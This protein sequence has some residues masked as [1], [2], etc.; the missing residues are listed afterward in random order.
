M[1][2]SALTATVHD[3]RPLQQADLRPPLPEDSVIAGLVAA[4]IPDGATLQ[5]GVGGTPDA[6]LAGLGEKNDLGVHSGMISDAVVD[7]I[8]A[9]VVTNRAKGID[10]GVTVTGALFGSDRLYS[11][12]DRNPMFAMRPVT[13]THDAAVLASV[14]SLY[15]INSAIEV[16]LTGQVNGEVAAGQYVGTV[17]GQ[18]A[19]ARAAALST[20]GRAIVALPSTARGGELSRIVARTSAGVTS[21]ARC[22][23]DLVVTEH[24]VADLRGA[25]LAERRVRL[26]AIADPR[27]RDALAVAP[28]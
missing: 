2:A 28:S 22:D 16:D 21:T 23:A 24:G 3:D 26:L 8:E 12:A 25:T 15:A 13:Y 20:D 1:P 11:W 17:G 6:V 14:R 4:L 7:L 18:P 19:F 27:D 10:E 9:G 5:F